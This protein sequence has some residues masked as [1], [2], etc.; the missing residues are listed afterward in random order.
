MK[1]VVA[2]VVGRNGELRVVICPKRNIAYH[3]GE[4]EVL[5]VLPGLRVQ[6]PVSIGETAALVAQVTDYVK[7][8]EKWRQALATRIS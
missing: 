8:R 5:Y 7:E 3:L 4:D 2:G 1:S 6:E